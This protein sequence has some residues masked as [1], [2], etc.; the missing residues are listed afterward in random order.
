MGRGEG[1]EG[2]SGGGEVLGG[3]RGRRGIGWEVLKMIEG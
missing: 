1:L 3:I 2:V